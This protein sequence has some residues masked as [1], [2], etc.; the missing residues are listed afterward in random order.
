MC[1][2][3]CVCVRVHIYN[4]GYQYFLFFSGHRTF[5]VRISVHT[6][7]ILR[8]K[9]YPHCVLGA[10]HEPDRPMIPSTHMRERDVFD[11]QEVTERR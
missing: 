4:R 11:N 9:P 6:F 3:V 7:G 10:V 1:V 8:A 2:Y 5:Y